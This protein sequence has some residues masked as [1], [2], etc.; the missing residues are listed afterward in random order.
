MSFSLKSL[1]LDSPKTRKRKQEEAE[2]KERTRKGEIISEAKTWIQKQKEK[3]QAKPKKKPYQDKLLEKIRA[4]KPLYD[5]IMES[6]RFGTFH[7]TQSEP[8]TETK[9]TKSKDTISLKD[10]EDAAN[11]LH[12]GK[13]IPALGPTLPSSIWDD[14]IDGL[15][16]HS[17]SI[18]AAGP[19]QIYSSAISTTY[20]VIGS[21]VA[22]S[23][24]F[25]SD[26]MPI[27][28]AEEEEELPMP[29]KFRSPIDG[30][31]YDDS[32]NPEDVRYAFVVYPPQWGNR[33]IG[34]SFIDAGGYKNVE[35]HFFGHYEG[36]VEEDR[37]PGKFFF[38]VGLGTE[39]QVYLGQRLL[40]KKLFKHLQKK[41]KMEQKQD[42]WSNSW[43]I[44]V[45]QNF[46]GK[47]ETDDLIGNKQENAYWIEFKPK[48]KESK[49]TIQIRVTKSRGQGS[50]SHTY[51]A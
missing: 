35:V 36:C 5:K 13:K 51:D 11:K 15:H 9:P 25:G 40:S 27:A 7:E 49:T 29:E 47:D 19:P 14:P 6:Q 50:G 43:Y 33:P 8:T 48:K 39:L 38:P 37:E 24:W 22:V 45:T 23:G 42:W 41:Y 16:T 30:I 10:L 18:S 1:L 17:I 31:T 2:A 32:I 21:A 46:W 12:R 26:S 20:P 3:R 34:G 4:E 28:H 44:Q